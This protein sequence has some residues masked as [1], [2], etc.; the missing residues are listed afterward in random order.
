MKINPVTND[1]NEESSVFNSIG[2]DFTEDFG[3]LSIFKWTVGF[4][5]TYVE[6]YKWAE[7]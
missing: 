5:N 6:F 3:E 2:K 1:Q 7:I 4:W